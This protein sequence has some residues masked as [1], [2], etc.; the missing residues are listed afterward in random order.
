M[1]HPVTELFSLCAGLGTLLTCT[2]D[3]YIGHK[4]NMKLTNKLI[5]ALGL[6][7]AG[8]SEAQTTGAGSADL[9]LLGHR[10]T[11]LNVGLQDIKHLSDHG[12][13]VGA[14]ANNALIPGVLDAGASYS[15]SWIR[16]PFRGHAN[17]IGGYATAYAPFNGV[18][19]FAGA[20]LGYQWSS[21]GFGAD[22][23]QALWGL[24]A[25]VEIPAGPG[26]T[27]TPRVNYADDF[28]SSR[29]SSQVWTYQVEL[30]YWYN[31]RSAVFGSIGK[32][33]VRRTSFDSWNYELGLRAR[34]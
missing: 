30:N 11:E 32:S 13:I 16:G 9:G 2:P 6:L 7:A 26:L 17:T 21:F 33:D 18:K 34:F 31:A 14:S 10:Y 8:V 24:T 28:E 5:V 23:D 15:Y 1:F 27:I 20:G 19:P 4:P 12:Y 22:D 25:G 3:D 29:N